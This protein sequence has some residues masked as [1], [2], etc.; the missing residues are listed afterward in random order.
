MAGY[1]RSLDGVRALAIILVMLFH[2]YYVLEIGWIGVQIFFVLSGYLITNILVESKAKSDLSPYLK[3]FYWRRTLRIFPLYYFYLL[4]VT[5]LFL[6]TGKPA[7]FPATAAYLYTYTYNI[8]PL[9]SEFQFD[10]FFTHFWSLCVEEQFYLFWPLL[11][12]LFNRKQ[13][14]VMIISLIMF[15]PLFR[16]I[17]GSW[18]LENTYHETGEILYRFTLSHFDAFAWGGSIAIFRLNERVSMKYQTV[19]LSVSLAILIVFGLFNLQSY[20]GVSTITSLGYPI[21]GMMN[22]Q[23]VWSYT[24]INLFAT[25][26]ILLLITLD[27]RPSMLGRLF[28]NKVFIEIGKISYGMYVYHWILLTLYRVYIHP[29]IQNLFVSFLVYSMLVFAVSWLSYE[30]LEKFF[31]KIKE[32]KSFG[33]VNSTR[34]TAPKV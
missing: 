12:Y 31:L 27:R 19:A 15:I 26:L 18:L 30:C 6:F 7:N 21:G 20:Q 11:I 13:Q 23:H 34:K 14:K 9:F 17:F 3:R 25:C 1:I 29:Y 32:K 24:V 22:F 4:A 28:G 16:M 5:V 10:S 8:Q 2:F 33:V